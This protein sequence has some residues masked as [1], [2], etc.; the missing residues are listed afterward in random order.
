[1]KVVSSCF[2]M[3]LPLLCGSAVA[4]DAFDIDDL[5]F[6][7]FTKWL[8]MIA[9]TAGVICVACNCM[10]LSWATILSTRAFAIKIDGLSFDDIMDDD[11]LDDN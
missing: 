10:I 5:F 6:I 9:M 4:F 7:Y 11:A 3:A 2:K 8:T 1:M